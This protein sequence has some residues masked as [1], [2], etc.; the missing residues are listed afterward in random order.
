[1]HTRGAFLVIVVAATFF[2][3]CAAQQQFFSPPPAKEIS[4][5]YTQGENSGWFEPCEPGVENSMWWVTFTGSSAAQFDQARAANQ[6]V[7]GERYFVRFKAAV[8]KDG[9][10]GPQGP[11]VPALLVSEILEIRPATDGDCPPPAR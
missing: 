10:V 8:T 11:G 4:G 7:S 3:G 1:M 5:H 2:T 6:L 9:E